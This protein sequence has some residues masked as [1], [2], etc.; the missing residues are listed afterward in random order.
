MML[1]VLCLS[2]VQLLRFLMQCLT[3]PGL[4]AHRSK[5]FDAQRLTS[6]LDCR[7]PFLD[8]LI[9]LAQRRLLSTDNTTRFVLCELI[10]CQPGLGLL[11]AAFKDCSFASDFRDRFYRFL[12]SRCHLH[13]CRKMVDNYR[14]R[15]LVDVNSHDQ[16]LLLR[17]MIKLD[18]HVM[19]TTF[20][21]YGQ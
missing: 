1:I 13:R 18:H 3:L 17:H 5:A 7:S 10:L 14:Q 15:D 4:T 19:R 6:F 11:F 20:F 16:K 21:C 2:I 9:L 8:M 12:S